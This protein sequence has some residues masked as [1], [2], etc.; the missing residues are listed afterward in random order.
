MKARRSVRGR[1][2]G[3]FVV[4]AMV[5]ASLVLATMISVAASPE[6]PWVQPLPAPPPVPVEARAQQ[7]VSAVPALVSQ[8][9]A[10]VPMPPGI[11]A[12]PQKRANQALAVPLLGLSTCLAL[13]LVALRWRVG[14][15]AGR[16][17]FG[18]GR[19]AA[20]CQECAS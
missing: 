11:P 10:P 5:V 3:G 12:S 20:A 17:A 4:L 8:R 19:A 7:V 15:P 13:G 6:E 18:S 1:L 2:V 16:A 14:L 9:P